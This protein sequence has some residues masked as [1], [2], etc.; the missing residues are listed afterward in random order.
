ME[1][2]IDVPCDAH[3]PADY[4]AREDLRLEAYRRLASVTLDTEVEDIKAEWLDRFGPLPTAAEGLLAVARLRAE[5]L[6]VGAREISAT[7]A[8]PG[9]G[10]GPISGRGLIAR[11]SPVALAASARVRLRRLRPEATFKE[12]LGRL[13]VPLNPGEDPVVA[14][15]ELLGSLVPPQDQ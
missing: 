3:L 12:D 14:L 11:V 1:V 10:L 13:I 9:E 15:T 5:C 7:R 4:V 8:R 6:R 2:T